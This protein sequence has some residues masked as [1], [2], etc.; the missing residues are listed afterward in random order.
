[1]V[2]SEEVVNAVGI[3]GSSTEGS[4]RQVDDLLWCAGESGAT[5]LGDCV[6]QDKLHLFN[7]AQ[8]WRCN[9]MMAS[10]ISMMKWTNKWL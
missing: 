10:A 8:L 4:Y 2:E 7:L 3:R 6:T 5:W 9:G 1:M